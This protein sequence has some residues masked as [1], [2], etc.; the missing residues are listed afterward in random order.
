M[1]KNKFVSG[2][3]EGAGVGGVRLSFYNN[4]NETK[5]NQTYHQ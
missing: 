1:L 3:G 2:P 5:L 4:E